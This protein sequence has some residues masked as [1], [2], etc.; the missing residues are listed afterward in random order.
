MSKKL[1]IDTK[2][3]LVFERTTTLTIDQI[4]KAWTNSNTLKKWFCPKPWKVTNC[5]IDL[6]A[7]GEFYTFMKGPNGEKMP[8]NS[9][10]LEVIKNKKLVWTNLLSENYRPTKKSNM[11][12]SFV[13]T[14]LLS[15]TKKGTLY[16]AIVM[17]A[18]AEERNKH[19]SMGFQDGWGKAFQQLEEL[20]K[21]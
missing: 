18:N 16:K 4:W 13:I 7:G 9:S 1:K 14:L 21:K 2:L 11:G 19:K 5:R 10:Y 8:N 6:R 17:H 3:D 12:F 20:M 15:K